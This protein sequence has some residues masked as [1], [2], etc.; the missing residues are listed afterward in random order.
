MINYS[1]DR[2]I[3]K[4]AITDNKLVVFVGAGASINS[5]I[6]LWKDAV[7]KIYERIGSTALD[8]N[9]TLKIPQVYFNARGEK[10]YNELVKD[11]F[12]YD[13]KNPNK[14]HELI[15]KLNPCHVITTNYD[16]FLEKAFIANG[17]FLDVVQKDSEIPYSKNSR[18]IIKMH[19]GFTYNNFVFKEDDYLN[20]SHNFALIEIFI[21]ALVA[22]NVI[23]FVGYS[24]NDP[25]TKQIFNWV[26]NIL[27]DNFQRAYFFDAGNCYDL[28]TV[29][30]YKNLGINIIYSSECLRES[31]NKDSI[32]ENT[33]KVLE[34]IIND[35][36]ETDI[37][38][39]VYNA[40]KH[41]VGL[42][43][44]LAQ[45]IPYM[46]RNLDVVYKEGSLTLLSNKAEELFKSLNEDFLTKK[47][48][49]STIKELLD[50]TIIKNSYI[51]DAESHKPTILCNFNKAPSA[52]L[53]EDI[54][55]QNFINIKSYADSVNMAMQM[56]NQLQLRIAYSFYELQEYQK[57]YD[58][59]KKV[60]LTYK[61][62][63]NYIWYF[64]TE[65]NR[66]HVGRLISWRIYWGTNNE[67]NNETEKIDLSDI[68]YNN[69][70][71][72]KHENRFLKEL[73]N[74]TLM[75]KTLS[76]VLKFYEKVEKDANTNYVFGSGVANID[77]L[78]VSVMDFY[79]YLKLNHLMIDAYSEVLEVYKQYINAVFCS[80][81]KKEK[82]FSDG[83]FGSG[84]NKV[85]KEVSPF[86]IIIICKYID[87]KCL[88]DILQNNDVTKIKLSIDAENKLFE[89]LDNY[90]IAIENKILLSNLKD[91]L[92]VI[93]RILGMSNLSQERI[94]FIVNK[95]N[96]LMTQNYFE[97]TDF[98]EISNFIVKK[99]NCDKTL[100]SSETICLVIS[101]IC[102]GFRLK[103]WAETDISYLH[104]LFT[105]LSY[106][107]ND[108]FPNE[109][110]SDMLSEA[111]LESEY[112]EFF[113]EL[114]S[115]ASDRIKEKIKTEVLSKLEDNNFNYEL[116]YDSINGN[117]ISQSKEMEDKL[118]EK[119]K[120]IH[121]EQ[122]PS[123]KSYPDPLETI[124]TYCINL[125]LNGKLIDKDRFK[126][127]LKDFPQIKF[128]YDMNNFDYNKFELSWFTHA[129][130]ALKENI[131]QNQTAF[132]EIKKLYRKALGNN[133]YD[134]KMLNEYLKYF[135]KVK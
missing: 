53:Y 73:E 34:Y 52:K 123:T 55:N 116:Y 105:N 122:N 14:I 77:K 97:D 118:F 113:P 32:Y 80:H 23:L 119:V 71:K 11:I 43:Y 93:L 115:V 102:N 8:K 15:V 127:Y 68:L 9:D 6:P 24:Y 57:C 18:M 94:T 132:R 134:Q 19:G 82:E 46:F 89:I 110:I 124:L 36:Q 129:N 117:I 99:Y 95:I 126:P 7:Q 120:Q 121:N 45:Y 130:N 81:S 27:G 42:N 48:K 112:E 59:L 109:K 85:L 17:E 88:D 75:Y 39:I 29:N 86:T 51:Y 37:T 98:T 87:K 5:G 10:E 26:K 101:T 91:K 92:F 106:I 111:I 40:S 58:I 96:N 16:D 1:E 62:Q 103:I 49:L 31:F 108:V 30:Y 76:E 22:K 100:L 83:M 21:K 3:L 69:A 67:L 56:D 65:F 63:Q 2:R 38:N 79:N 135:D 66:L 28:N 90:F 61:R 47:S 72:G 4:Q 74:F 70:L 12:K 107:L 78:E 128:L 125:H 35:E 41:L 44:I 114:F 60:S 20:Y 133:D 84:K 13:G 104:T 50:K 64:I 54:D 25:D 131:V 33:V